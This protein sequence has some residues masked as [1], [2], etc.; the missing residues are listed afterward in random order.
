MGCEAGPD[1]I[2]GVERDDLDVEYVV[3][4][5]FEPTAAAP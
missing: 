5:R 2:L 3:R 1:D 4:Y